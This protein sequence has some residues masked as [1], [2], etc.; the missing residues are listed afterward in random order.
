M[1]N[2]Y[3][4]EVVQP[5]IPLSE[6]TELEF[7]VLSEV[8]GV[9]IYDA[10]ILETPRSREAYFFAEDGSSEIIWINREEAADALVTSREFSSCL[11]KLIDNAINTNE[12]DDIAVDIPNYV[13]ILH[14]IVKRSTTLT[15]ISIQQAF[16][17]DKMRPDS[18][19]GG[20]VLITKKEVRSM[21]TKELLDQW[22][23]EEKLT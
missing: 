16:Y 5:T 12:G 23:N 10:D 3:F 11:N 1:A 22:L 9:E 14:D 6:M 4:P 21:T 13:D 15:H 18:V 19:G 8:Y 20:L 7:L 2:S 17:C